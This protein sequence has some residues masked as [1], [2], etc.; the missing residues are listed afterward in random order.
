MTTVKKVFLLPAAFLVND[1]SLLEFIEKNNMS[2]QQI[3]SRIQNES[4]VQTRADVNGFNWTLSGFI[5][6]GEDKT[7]STPTFAGS[8]SRSHTAGIEIDK[9]WPVGLKAGLSYAHS[10]TN[11]L[12][13][14][15]FN[16]W[17]A[18]LSKDLFPYFW[19]SSSDFSIESI[20][21]GSQ[22]VVADL[23]L[24][25]RTVIRNQIDSFGKL[26]LMQSQIKVNEDLLSKYSVIVKSVQRKR[27]NNFST[28]GELEQAQAE[29][30]LRETN[31]KNLRQSYAKMLEDFISAN[32]SNSSDGIEIA[33]V[34]FEK[35]TN[36][37]LIDELTKQATQE[38]AFNQLLVVRAAQL[39]AQASEQSYEGSKKDGKP[40]L[41][42]YS[43][44]GQTG[45][46]PSLADSFG[47]SQRD[48]F[49]RYEVGLRL[50]H[51]F[52]GDLVDQ[53]ISAKLLESTTLKRTSELATARIP[54]QISIGKMDLQNAYDQ[55]KAQSEILELRR[56]AM[57]QISQNYSQGRIDI[58]LLFD[59]YNKMVLSEISKVEALNDLRLKRFDLQT[60]LLK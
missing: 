24:S 51:E 59:A 19:G 41:S 48:K 46:D 17:E 25:K 10:Q 22:A 27:A 33:P 11:K 8:L 20:K 12:S 21:V 54:L 4:V 14:Y 49:S 47:D 60:L 13:G 16:E 29:F 32:K 50:T 15:G 55:L 5:A 18:E 26:Q 56:T 31:L 3:N 36:I 28:A 34:E 9:T 23:I 57:N 45:L 2:L 1:S 58:S 43:T 30:K 44:Y 53:T 42:L 52:D 7:P 37:A 38:T 40:M 35:L 39:R 6:T